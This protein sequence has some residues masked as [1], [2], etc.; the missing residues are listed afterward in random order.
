MSIAK[1]YLVSRRD[2]AMVFFVAAIFVL[3][4]VYSVF[5]A[6]TIGDNIS[7][8]GTLTVDSTAT[9]KAAVYASSTLQVDGASVHYGN[10]AIG[11]ATSSIGVAFTV[12]GNSV[13]AGGAVFNVMPSMPFFQATSTTA[14]ST[15]AYGLTTGAGGLGVGTTSP[16]ATLGVAGNAIIAD[17]AT[18]TLTMHA[19]TGSFGGCIEFKASSPAGAYVRIYAGAGPTAVGA[20]TIGLVVES[21]RCR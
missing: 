12:H 13:F 9:L 2:V 1:A 14:T 8:G 18:T 7:T 6:T 10:V 20:G 19:T 21:G 5:S 3:A 17:S 16:A 15:L 4:V 11:D